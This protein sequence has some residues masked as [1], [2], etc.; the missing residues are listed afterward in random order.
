[1]TAETI[2]RTQGAPICQARKAAQRAASPF[3]RHRLSPGCAG[4]ECLLQSTATLNAGEAFDSWFDTY[5]LPT[6]IEP[7]GMRSEKQKFGD[8]GI[9]WKAEKRCALCGDSG[10]Y[11]YKCPNFQQF[12]AFKSGR[13]PPSCRARPALVAC[14]GVVRNLQLATGKYRHRSDFVVANIGQDD[15]IVGTDQLEP[16]QGGFAHERGFW[17]MTVNGE[18]L[19]I[20]LIGDCFLCTSLG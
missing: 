7:H 9:G 18:E 10:H 3:R 1:M 16:A 8:A 2:R 6:E 5:P 4:E 12:T 17:K 11:L 19:V 15:V 14:Q 13:Q 20:P